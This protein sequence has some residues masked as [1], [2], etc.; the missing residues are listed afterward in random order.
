MTTIKTYNKSKLDNTINE[1]NKRY[2]EICQLDIGFFFQIRQDVTISPVVIETR[3]EGDVM[4]VLQSHLT[5]I[6]KTCGGK[7]KNTKQKCNGQEYQLHFVL[8]D[9]YVK[10]RYEG[11]VLILSSAVET[12]K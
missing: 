5:T 12:F 4:D 9:L 3:M 6:H 2:A 11:D 7:L 10:F 8:S 1:I